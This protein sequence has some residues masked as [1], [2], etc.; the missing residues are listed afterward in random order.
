[1]ARLLDVASGEIGRK[2]KFKSWI[3]AKKINKSKL[4][5]WLNFK[6]VDTF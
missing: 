3:P 2:T 4:T 1:M 6:K 5:Y